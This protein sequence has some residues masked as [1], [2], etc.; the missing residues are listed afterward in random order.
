TVTE[1][2]DQVGGD[3]AGRVLA[4]RVGLGVDAAER[5]LAQVGVGDRAPHRVLDLLDHL[6]GERGGH[7]AVE[8]REAAPRLGELGAYVEVVGAELVGG[9]PGDQAAV[10]RGDLRVGDQHQAVDRLGQR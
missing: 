3:V 1:E 10:L 5:D 9:D 7:P 2:A 6:G 4:Q 8:V